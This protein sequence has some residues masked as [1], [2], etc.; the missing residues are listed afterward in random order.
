MVYHT[1]TDYKAPI[2]GAYPPAQGG[3]KYFMLCFQIVI[4]FVKN[5]CATTDIGD[6]C[7]FVICITEYPPPQAEY[8]PPQAGYPPPQAGYPPPQA[9]YPPGYPP[10]QQAAYPPA[11]P[12]PPPYP[13]PSGDYQPPPP[14]PPEQQPQVR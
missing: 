4:S 3:G 8:P 11:E 12:V 5:L 13:G 9:G 1:D 7:T 2:D 6:T 10:N 14:A